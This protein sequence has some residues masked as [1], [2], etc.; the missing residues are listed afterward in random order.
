VADGVG[1][2]YAQAIERAASEDFKPFFNNYINRDAVVITDEWIEY[3][4]LKKEYQHLKQVPSNEGK[5][6]PDMHIYIMNLKG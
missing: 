5:N 3:S 1:R 6:F 4:P 2:A